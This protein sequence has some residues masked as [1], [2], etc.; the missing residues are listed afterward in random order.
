MERIKDALERAKKQRDQQATG[1]NRASAATASSSPDRLVKPAIAGLHAQEPNVANDPAPHRNPQTVAPAPA[2]LSLDSSD[3][4]SPDSDAEILPPL[5]DVDAPIESDQV[6][7]ADFRAASGGHRHDYVKKA[8]PS[9][10]NIT[11][12]RT[13]QLEIDP[14]YLQA[15]R[16]ISGLDDG[17]AEYYRML[18]THVSQAMRAN[19]WQSLAITSP[20]PGAGKSVTSLNLAIALARDVNRTVLLV[21]LDLRK[22]TLRTYLT[23]EKIPGISDYL[24]DD[25]PV[26]D[27]LVTIG[28]DRLVILPG[29]KSIM[30]SAEMLSS[31]KM[32]ALVKELKERYPSRLIVF[33]MPPVLACDD[34]VAFSPYFD[35]A[36]LIIEESGTPKKA[37]EQA[38]SMLDKTNILGTVLN[39][40]RNHGDKGYGYGYYYYGHDQQGK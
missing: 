32:L 11:Y 31:P 22:P 36:L 17:I 9:E 23:N 1:G 8:V 30:H 7:M 33:D 3:A 25:V 19:Q 16:V 2:D 13:R 10:F 37:L 40:S 35:A 21:D 26:E 27:L 14:A 29:N 15:H 24:I 34:V 12:S 38:Y 28:V 20:N 6:V 39:K 5:G 4:L 18:R